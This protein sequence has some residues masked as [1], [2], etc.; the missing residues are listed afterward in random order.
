MTLK[1]AQSIARANGM[2]IRKAKSGYYEVTDLTKAKD[3]RSTFSELTVG[4]ALSQAKSMW[5]R[6]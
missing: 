2:S 1:Q 4:K 6:R 3:V 5:K